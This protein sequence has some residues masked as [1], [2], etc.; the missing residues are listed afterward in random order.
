MKCV[1]MLFT[2]IRLTIAQKNK[3]KLNSESISLLS[4][5]E[6]SVLSALLHIAK[7]F[8]FYVLGI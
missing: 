7:I 4:F 1:A 6:F 2:Q 5:A 8:K 3:M